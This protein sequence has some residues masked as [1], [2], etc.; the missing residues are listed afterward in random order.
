M[1][2]IKNGRVRQK[3]AHSGK[4]CMTILRMAFN[5]RQERGWQDKVDLLEWEESWEYFVIY[6]DLQLLRSSKEPI[7]L[8][9]VRQELLAAKRMSL[10]NVKALVAQR[11][12]D[13]V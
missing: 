5:T 6:L 7:R 4:S 9:E 2:S 8:A 13:S 11:L 10:A 3:K 1:I 12:A